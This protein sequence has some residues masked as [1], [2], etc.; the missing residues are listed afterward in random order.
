MGSEDFGLLGLEGHKIPTVIF[1]L[2]AMDPAKL[3]AATSAG[4]ELPGLHSNRFEPL[5]EPTLRG[6][7]ESHD[8]AGAMALLQ[9]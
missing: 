4:K 6:G 7:I 2:G 3:A 9:N 1:W 5:P 8:P